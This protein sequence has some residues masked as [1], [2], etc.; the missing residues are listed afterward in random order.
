MLCGICRANPDVIK[1]QGLQSKQIH[2]I[3]I[4]CVTV[5]YQREGIE[6]LKP[7]V[8]LL[9]SLSSMKVNNINSMYLCSDIKCNLSFTTANPNIRISRKHNKINDQHSKLHTHTFHYQSIVMSY[10]TFSGCKM[11]TKLTSAISH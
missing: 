8:E 6:F 5:F 3:I 2:G 9:K 4:H 11:F 1:M 7:C 10:S